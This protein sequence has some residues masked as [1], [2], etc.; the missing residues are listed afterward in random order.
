M[1][2]SDFK[3]TPSK[4]LIESLIQEVNMSPGA[5]RDYVKKFKGDERIGIEYEMYVPDGDIDAEAEPEDDSTMDGQPESF[6]DIY[7]FFENGNSNNIGPND[8]R[9]LRN[10]LE[11]DYTDWVTDK[12]HDMYA[13]EHADENDQEAIDDSDFIRYSEE[14][15]DDPKLSERAFLR[16]KRLEFYSDIRHE[17]RLPWPYTVTPEFEVS[18]SF[19]RAV[20]RPVEVYSYHGG[21]GTQIN[22]YRIEFDGSLDTPDELQDQGLEFISPPLNFQETVKDLLAIKKWCKENNCYANSTTGL[23]INISLPGY[24]M[25]K[26]DYVKLALFLGDAH[27]LTQFGRAGNEYCESALEKIKNRVNQNNALEVLE[28]MRT[29]IE[30]LA[31]HAIHGP[32]TDKYVSINVKGNRVEFRSPGGDWISENTDKLIDTIARCIT[33]LSIAMDPEEAHDEYAKKLYKLLTGQEFGR[34]YIDPEAYTDPKTMTPAIGIKPEQ[35]AGT[36]GG[37]TRYQPTVDPQ[38]DLIRAFVQYA[39]GN[40]T[41]ETFKLMIRATQEQRNLARM[42]TAKPEPEAQPEPDNLGNLDQPM[43]WELYD[44]ATGKTVF[45]IDGLWNI[46]DAYHRALPPLQQMRR[47][48]DTRLL[49]LRPQG[50]E[51]EI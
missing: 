5:L 34:Y 14:H 10:E 39:T 38:N 37:K 2:Y 29:G 8:I 11:S 24:R 30:T 22:N 4:Q 17:Y 23:H 21:A 32:Y 16:A 6:D 48:G 13:N 51:N 3:L 36:H 43:A 12:L 28:K 25:S 1:R 47:A 7:E 18:T 45:K 19:E 42:Q 46:T 20:R 33:A 27:V 49:R 50:Q 44:T 9:I 26:L 41:Q 31:S 40:Y 35:P 15:T